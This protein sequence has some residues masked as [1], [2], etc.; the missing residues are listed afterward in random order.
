IIMEEEA[1]V[2]TV[3]PLPRRSIGE[4][5][6]LEFVNV[7][8]RALGSAEQEGKVCKA[9]IKEPTWLSKLQ[10]SAP[11]DGYLLEGG[12]F[13]ASFKKDERITPGLKVTIVVSCL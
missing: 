1:V 3:D 13:F 9:V 2:S 8:I 6:D 10:P 7:A 11:L 12:K 5:L 4:S